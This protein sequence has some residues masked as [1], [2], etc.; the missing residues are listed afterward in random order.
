VINPGALV[1]QNEDLKSNEV[2]K[3]PIGTV[4]TIEEISG[5]RARISTPLQGWCSLFAKDGRLILQKESTK[6]K[7]MDEA[8][9]AERTHQTKI[10]ILKSI[11]TLNDA[12]VIRILEK[13]DWNLRRA[14]EAFYIAKFKTQEYL[15][16]TQKNEPKTPNN[17]GN[18]SPIT[19]NPQTNTTSPNDSSRPRKSKG[20]WK[21]WKTYASQN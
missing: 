19:E 8:V 7:E 6:S 17:N 4:V 9:A 13:S 1:K 20:W 10:L 12:T 11:T 16:Q 3:I 18:L 5:R 21:S 2:G 14:I 15:K